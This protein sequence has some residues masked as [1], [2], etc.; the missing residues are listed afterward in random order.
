MKL[1]LTIKGTHCNSCKLLIEEACAEIAGVQSCTV[2]F[3]TGKTVIEHD[4]KLDIKKLQK[5]IEGLGKY[6]VII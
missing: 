4:G 5:E 1:I 6:K 3:K 2:D